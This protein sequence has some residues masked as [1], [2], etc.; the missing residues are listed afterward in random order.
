MIFVLSLHLYSRIM[1]AKNAQKI[2]II[3]I[4]HLNASIVQ[5]RET[6]MKRKRN[7]NVLK[8]YSGLKYNALSATIRNTLILMK[9]N[10][11]P[12]LKIKFMT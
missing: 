7:V 1:P 6:I 5:L 9:R 10:A 11:N 8:D 3:M 2:P 12:V 4:H